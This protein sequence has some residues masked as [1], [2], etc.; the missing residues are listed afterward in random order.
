[1]TSQSKGQYPDRNLTV[2]KEGGILDGDT[3]S[4]T[5]GGLV[6]D[7]DVSFGGEA[8]GPDGR[9]HLVLEA[10]RDDARDVHT[11]VVPLVRLRWLFSC[12]LLPYEVGRT[13]VTGGLSTTESSTP[14]PNGRK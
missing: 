11:Q 5:L 3:S 13:L 1:M 12:T 8:R 4:T 10:V 7:G 2:Q 6:G 9:R 14:V